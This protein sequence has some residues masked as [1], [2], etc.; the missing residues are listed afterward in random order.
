MKYL[1]CTFLL[2]LI[3]VT[4]FS[5]EP[6][7]KLHEMGLYPTIKL[8]YQSCDCP[9]CRANPEESRSVGSGVIIRSEKSTG[10]LFKDKYVNVV[11]TAT[12][13]V[14]HAKPPITIHVGKYKD[15]SE[16]DGFDNYNSIVYAKDKKLDIA[17]MLF[18]SEKKLYVANL[19]IDKKFYLG[20]RVVRF[21]YGLGDDV[22]FDEGRITSVK[23]VLPEAMSGKARMNAHTVFGDSGGPVYDSEYNVIG[24]THAIRSNGFTLLTE[25]SYFARVSD[26]KTWNESINNTVGFVYKASDKLPC[27]TSMFELWL[28]D[29][30]IIGEKK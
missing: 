18:V 27:A 29:Y 1:F 3:P 13:N 30:Q 19:G 8:T 12:H 25:Q 23:T 16:I 22:R 15:W 9:I 26:I 20:N 28:L 5:G 24:I 2:A 11:L 7:K 10:P 17:V 21:G 14:E 6:D 4:V